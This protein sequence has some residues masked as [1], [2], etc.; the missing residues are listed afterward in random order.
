NKEKTG[1][2]EEDKFVSYKGSEE[3]PS[4]VLLKNN[5]L[6]IEIQ[7]DRNHPVGKSDKA[8]I[9]DI[10][11]EAAIT[12]IMDC[13]DSVAAVDAEDKTFVYRNWLGI[14]K[15]DLSATFVKNGKQ[16]TRVFNEDREYKSPD[17]GTF[18]L[19]G[20]SLLFV[21]NVGHLMT[22]EAILDKDGREVP[23]GIMDGV[24]TS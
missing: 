16:M 9:K 17:G 13:E 22:S 5:R 1:L 19:K 24:V 4:A 7:I 12:T 3:E 8:G 18:K 20:R 21:R 10:I 14:V 6:H 23:E 11:L 15:G 2:K